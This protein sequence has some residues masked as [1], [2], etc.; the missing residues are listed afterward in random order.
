M[1]IC[2]LLGRWIIVL[3]FLIPSLHLLKKKKKVA[4][5]LICEIKDL[6]TPRSASGN[7]VVVNFRFPNVY[8]FNNLTDKFIA[9]IPPHRGTWQKISGQ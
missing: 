1:F 7:A 5:E 3:L 6:D 2:F 8:H 4:Y 9:L